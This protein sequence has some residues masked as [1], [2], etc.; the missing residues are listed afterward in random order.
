MSEKRC[1]YE[2][3]GVER[4]AS[5]E[6]IRK[7]YRQNALK[8]HPDRNP[9]DPGAT[10][11]FKEATE[12]FSVLSDEEKR[13]RYDQYGHA[14]LEGGGRFL[15]RGDGRHLLPVPRPVF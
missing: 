10:A 13:G 14:G 4:S 3:L 6:E 9:N 12:A 1:Y 11:K 8:Y 15:G 5:E 7:S 2:I